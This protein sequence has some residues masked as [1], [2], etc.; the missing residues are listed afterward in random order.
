MIEDHGHEEP[1][2]EVEE[3]ELIVIELADIEE[4]AKRGERPP[5]AHLYKFR[6]DDQYYT[7]PKAELTGRE[8]LAFAGKTPEAYQLRERL[9]GGKVVAIAPDEIVDLCRHGV[10]RFMTIPRENTDGGNLHEH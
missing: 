5:R 2:L 6:V 10:E 4:Y 8:I 3:V 1:V 7:T 9:R